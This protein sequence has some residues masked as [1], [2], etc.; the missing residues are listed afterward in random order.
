MVSRLDVVGFWINSR[1]PIVGSKVDHQRVWDPRAPTP[2]VVGVYSRERPREN[3]WHR[4][5]TPA[6]V[7]NHPQP[8]PGGSV[9]LGPEQLPNLEIPGCAVRLAVGVRHNALA[10]VAK[11]SRDRISKKFYLASRK[12]WRGNGNVCCRQG[13]CGIRHHAN[14][15][16]SHVVWDGI[17]S[18]PVR[19]CRLCPQLTVYMG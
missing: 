8:R 14:A 17:P 11:P 15:M 4:R 13:N 19:F 9:H 18:V 16:E 6:A 10:F 1:T 7:V 12:W 2:G 5:V 3:R